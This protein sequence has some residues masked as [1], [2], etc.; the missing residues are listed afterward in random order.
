VFGFGVQQGQSG[1]EIHLIL[2]AGVMS[3]VQELDFGTDARNTVV[4]HDQ[5]MTVTPDGRITSVIPF[6]SLNL[7]EHYLELPTVARSMVGPNIMNSNGQVLAFI[8][9]A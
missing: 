7:N 2:L 5:I 1:L 3:L 4:A 6:L 9:L 8:P